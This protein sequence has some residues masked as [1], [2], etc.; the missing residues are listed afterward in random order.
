MHPLM[1][2]T[3]ILQ[4]QLGQNLQCKGVVPITTTIG[5]SNMCLEY[6]IFHHPGLTFILVEVPLCALLRGADDGECLKMAVGQQEFS[7]SFARTINHAAEDKI[8][9]DL[10][11]QVMATTLDEELTPPCIDDVADYF[12]LAEEDAVFQDLQQ[13]AKPKT[14]PVELK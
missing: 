13:E 5:G 4:W 12:S 9:E 14:S 7:T 1:P 11:L 3:K 10:L 2:S 8:G 6:H